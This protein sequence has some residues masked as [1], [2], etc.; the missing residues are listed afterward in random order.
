[1]SEVGHEVC[2]LSSVFSPVGY[3]GTS[4]YGVQ[5]IL[6]IFL[7]IAARCETSIKTK[8]PTTSKV[9]SNLLKV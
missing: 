1:M 4:P 3:G 6:N 7:C 5:V 2:R 9:R 8:G